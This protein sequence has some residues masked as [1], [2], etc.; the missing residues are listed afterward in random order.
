MLGG[1]AQR[2][3]KQLQQGKLTAWQRVV[4]FLDPGT[5]E[6]RGAFVEHQCTNFDMDRSKVPGDGVVTGCGQVHGRRVYVYSQDF[7]VFGGSL[8][9]THAEKIVRLLKE[10]QAV[11]A[12]VVGLHDSGGAR[13]QEGVQALAGYADV[14]QCNIEASGV[15]PQVALVMGPCAGGAVYSPALMDFIFMVK[16]TSYMFLTGPEVVESVTGEVVTK[17]ELGGAATHCGK[18]GVAHGAFANDLEALAATRELLSYLPS[19]NREPAPR[20]SS[21]DPVTRPCADLENAVPRS[22]NAPYDMKAIVHS[23]VD[24]GQFFEIAPDFAKNIVVGLARVGGRSVG[25]VANQPLALAGVLDARASR[26][27]ARFVNFCDAFGIPLLTLVDVPGFLPGVGQEHEGVIAHGAKLL[28]AYG[29]ATVPKVTL[30]T[31]KAYG[32]AYC[33]MAS[34]HLKSDVNLAWPTA[35]VAVMGAEGATRIIFRGRD[36]GKLREETDRYAR[37]FYTPLAAA[38]YGYIDDIVNPTD[39]RTVISRA[40]DRLESKRETRT[41][42]KQGNIPL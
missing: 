18:S 8:G 16:D 41:A 12:P 17:Q 6:P 29:N 34:K 37:D 1:S 5:F 27:A 39:T 4:A 15:V 11:G 20:L 14:F 32:G 30:I 22:S 7:T 23:I 25:V 19:S 26:K 24:D 38:R 28:Y 13:I 36:D 33:V 10:A 42:R 3:Q 35:E 21:P 40:F 9:I 2:V 31:R